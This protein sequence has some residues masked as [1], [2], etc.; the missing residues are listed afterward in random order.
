MV[1]INCTWIFNLYILLF[2]IM[3]HFNLIY[4]FALYIEKFFNNIVLKI[5]KKCFSKMFLIFDLINCKNLIEIN[6]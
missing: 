4:L 1:V 6:H 2:C 3:R 5:K